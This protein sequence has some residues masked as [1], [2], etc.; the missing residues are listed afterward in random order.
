MNVRNRILIR[1]V[2]GLIVVWGLVFGIVKIAGSMKP[3]AEKVLSL[4]DKKPLSE[5]ED[6]EERKQV[7]GEVADM[8][9]QMEAS[10]VAILGDRDKSDP[11][12]DLFREMSPE[13]Q[14]YFFEKRV[15]RAFEQMMQSFNEMDRD[16]R[17]RIVERTLKQMQNGD[18]GS[19]QGRVDEQDPELAEKMA[20]AGLEAYYSDASVETKID[21]APLLEEMQRT[22]GRLGG[23]GR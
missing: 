18:D 12:R 7:I 16:E 1:G 6:A 20:E 14:R 10:E 22:M 8:L 23:R 21:L 15:G 9:N 4:F 19:R 3:T 17:K 13:E 2:F 11:R 5:I